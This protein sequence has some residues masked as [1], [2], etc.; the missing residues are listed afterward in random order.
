MGEKG[1]RTKKSEF[2]VIKIG[3]SCK[4]RHR[5]YSQEHFNVCVWC[6]MGTRPIRVIS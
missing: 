5:E 3:P 2:A 4:I 6:Q 1:E